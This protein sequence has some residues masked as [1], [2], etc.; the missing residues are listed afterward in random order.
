M[1]ADTREEARA[2]SQTFEDDSLS[3]GSALHA[4]ACSTEENQIAI[5]PDDHMLCCQGR[6]CHV[7][8]GKAPRTRQGK[9]M[10]RTENS[11]AFPPEVAAVG[12]SL[13]HL[14]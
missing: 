2:W 11:A 8:E 14:R 1:E 4:Q 7:T 6:F 3:H 12:P 9:E 10:A 13:F 5:M